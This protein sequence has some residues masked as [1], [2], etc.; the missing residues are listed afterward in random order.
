MIVGSEALFSVVAILLGG[1]V[2]N[3]CRVELCCSCLVLKGGRERAN[4]CLLRCDLVL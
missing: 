2:V 1:P 3:E 4:G